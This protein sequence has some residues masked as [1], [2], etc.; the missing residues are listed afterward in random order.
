MLENTQTLWFRHL[1]QYWQLGNN[2]TQEKEGSLK[3]L[4]EKTVHQVSPNEISVLQKLHFPSLIYNI[5]LQM[6]K[7]YINHIKKP[8]S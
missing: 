3:T 5:M 7:I 6:E 4:L 1:S 2:V 8:L